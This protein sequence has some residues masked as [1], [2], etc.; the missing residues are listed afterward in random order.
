MARANVEA[1]PITVPVVN[2]TTIYGGHGVLKCETA[3]PA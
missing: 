2:L 1:S 3:R